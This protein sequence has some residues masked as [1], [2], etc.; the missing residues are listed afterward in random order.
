MEKSDKSKTISFPVGSTIEVLVLQ[1]LPD[2]ILVSFQK[3]TSE[4]QGILL[5][6]SK[7]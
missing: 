5:D 3:G 7:G 6:S 1:A 4:Y 2:L